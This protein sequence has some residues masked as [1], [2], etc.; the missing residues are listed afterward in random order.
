MSGRST[1]K[2]RIEMTLSRHSETADTPKQPTTTQPTAD[3][4]TTRR[5]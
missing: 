4:T 2:D 5:Q 1:Q 3:D